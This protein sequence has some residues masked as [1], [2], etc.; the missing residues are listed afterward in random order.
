MTLF[1]AIRQLK[2]GQAIEKLGK[3]LDYYYEQCGERI[4]EYTAIEWKHGEPKM[5]VLKSGLDLNVD[6]RIINLPKPKM[7]LEEGLKQVEHDVFVDVAE[8][9]TNTKLYVLW[10][11]Q[12]SIGKAILCKLRSLPIDWQAEADRKEG[13]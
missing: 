7:S 12:P 2:E 4:A 3:G 10:S 11:K 8:T 5:T 9:D 13:K 6:V 1:E